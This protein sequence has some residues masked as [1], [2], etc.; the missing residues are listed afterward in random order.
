[1]EVTGGRSDFAM[2]CTCPDDQRRLLEKIAGLP[3]SCPTVCDGPLHLP[4]LRRRNE[5]QEVALEMTSHEPMAAVKL[6]IEYMTKTRSNLTR[7][8]EK[9]VRVFEKN[10]EQLESMLKDVS[11]GRS[12]SKRPLQFLCSVINHIVFLGSLSVPKC[13]WVRVLKARGEIVPKALGSM[14]EEPNRTHT[15]YK[16]TLRVRTK[17]GRHH[18]QDSVLQHFLG[19]VAHEMVHQ[20]LAHFPCRGCRILCGGHGQEFQILAGYVQQCL[21][22]LLHLK[23]DLHVGDS[24]IGDFESAGA[25]VKP[26]AHSIADCFPLQSCPM[27]YP[28]S[29]ASHVQRMEMPTS[30][31]RP[32]ELPI[33]RFKGGIIDAFYDMD[34]NGDIVDVPHQ[35]QTFLHVR[36]LP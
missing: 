22:T 9:A 7:R 8:Q 16:Y 34:A 18:R 24:V 2:D 33:P 23:P 3:C 5:E 27:H 1:M 12:L 13:L 10:Q 19:I 31:D 20:Y 30:P 11:C 4:V 25:S 28:E 32:F 17:L 14:S 21:T 36:S 26:C 35:G 29:K 6:A 15:K